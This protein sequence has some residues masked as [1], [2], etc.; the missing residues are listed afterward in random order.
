MELLRKKSIKT[1]A[2]NNK[3]SNTIYLNGKCYNIDRLKR[4]KRAREFIE[5]LI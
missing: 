3:Y 1:N 4:N 2:N 5:D